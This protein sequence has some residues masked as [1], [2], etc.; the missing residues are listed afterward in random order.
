MSRHVVAVLGASG[1]IGRAVV[2]A[3]AQ[4][5]GVEV[6]RHTG[7]HGPSG[8]GETAFELTDTTALDAFLAGA[9]AVIHAAG[10]P[11]VGSAE[12]APLV[13]LAAHVT[14]TA[15]VAERAALAGTHLVYV[16]S[17][18]AS[19]PSESVYAEAK[20]AAETVVRAW[21]RVSPVTIARPTH[22]YGPGGSP[23]T[24][25]VDLV[26]HVLEGGEARPRDPA[27]QVDLVYVDDVARSLVA[28]ALNAPPPPE[29]R[30]VEVRS[31]HTTRAAQVARHLR[32]L[33]RGDL[34]PEL[35]CHGPTPLVVGLAHTLAAARAASHM[36]T[37]EMSR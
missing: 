22:V 17:S 36:P 16:S 20:H 3:L 18:K 13:A 25:V 32:K 19:A 37:T 24:L 14:G 28:A 23:R 21:G 29:V 31:G 7:P 6:R 26:R 12:R 10:P 8:G 1:F 11:D 2:R 34:A 35:P 5:E 15:V 9:T 4:L 30:V 33:R 27:A